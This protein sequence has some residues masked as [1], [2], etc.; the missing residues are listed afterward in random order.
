MQF[1]NR[2]YFSDV[3]NSETTWQSKT[4]FQL[5]KAQS[6]SGSSK[7]PVDK[8]ESC[9]KFPSKSGLHGKNRPYPSILAYTNTKK[10]P[11]VS[12]LGI[13]KNNLSMDMSSIWSSHRATRI[14]SDNELDSR[15]TS[16]NGYTSF[17]ISRRLLISQPRSS[18]FDEPDLQS[19]FVTQNIRLGGEPR[20]IGNSA[21][22]R[23]RVFGNNMEYRNQQNDF[24]F[25]QTEP[26]SERI[27]GYDKQQYVELEKRNSFNRKTGFCLN[28]DSFRSTTFKK[29]SDRKP[30]TPRAKSNQKDTVVNK[31]APKLSLVEAKY[32]QRRS[33][34]P[35]KPNILSGNGCFPK[36]LGSKSKRRIFF[37]SMEGPPTGLAFQFKRTLGRMDCVKKEPRNSSESSGSIAVGQQNSCCIYKKGGRNEV[38]NSTQNGQKNSV[39]GGS[40]SDSFDPILCARKIQRC[41][42]S[43]IS[44]QGI[45]RL[46]S[47]DRNSKQDI[48]KMGHA[49]DRSVCHKAF[50]GSSELCND[51]SDRPASKIHQ[52]VQSDLEVPTGMD[53][54][55]TGANTQSIAASQRFGGNV[56]SNSSSMEKGV[57]EGGYKEQ[58]IR[59]SFSNKESTT[60]F[61]RPIE[62]STS[63]ECKGLLFGG[64]EN[65]SWGSAII[66]W[67]EEDINLLQ[68]AWR[69][70]T[71]KTYRSAWKEYITWCSQNKICPSK[72]SPQE[73]VQYLSH[74]WRSKKFKY[75]TILVHKSV[76]ATFLNP[77]GDLQ[78]SSHP[79][80][81]AILKAINIKDSL[82]RNP[83]RNLIWNIET[84]L[85]WM[86][87]NNL[88]ESSIFQVSRHTA[89]L[90]LLA[91]S[92]RIHDL[93]LLSLKEHDFEEHEDFV[94]FW[95]MFGSKTDNPRARQSGWR[96]MSSPDKIFNLVY[97][98]KKLME[99]SESRRRSV[100]NLNTLFITTR[101]V[102]K[103]A[104]R[105]IIAGWVK[106]AFQAVGIA[107]SPGSIRSA[108]SSYSFAK[109][110][111]LDEILKRGNW[112]G[113]ENFFKHYCKNIFR[114]EG[115]NDGKMFVTESFESV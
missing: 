4:N 58:S 91:S 98:I 5:E 104:S 106:T 114:A 30:Q 29:S 99:V 110:L 33:Y 107:D 36:R 66:G 89:L 27:E 9:A 72:A 26:D 10:S 78:L 76:I 62:Q 44:R 24:A 61:N 85:D 71:M 43:F 70:S 50:S 15:T 113:P 22:S 39:V 11:K 74:L 1:S 105:S 3:F 37:R 47:F 45:T 54:S 95:P 59:C 21:L 82:Q 68:S 73:I 75:S 103:A 42:G 13:W 17:G 7:V 14:L 102:V 40:I 67:N 79:M 51:G 88:N 28:G 31:S 109:E 20:K 94:I 2:I 101:G 48:S 8:P 12:R 65:T 97:W 111:P 23:D 18:D 25:G 19:N 84:L 57:L 100:N 49:R 93:T 41:S 87:N 35:A 60:E 115:L 83:Q 32:S 38:S 69:E 92:R 81:K 112:R 63:S 90:L 64:M 96:I 86:K 6:V 108:A 56:Y 16:R 34:F 53:I 52:R 46:A 77:H 55:P 80:I